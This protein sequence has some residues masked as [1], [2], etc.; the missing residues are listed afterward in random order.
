MEHAMTDELA[1]D[2]AELFACTE[3]SPVRPL[4]QL[5]QLVARTV[6]GCSGATATLW[7]VDEVVATAATH[8]D[9]AALPEGQFARGHGPVIDALRSGEP[10][11]IPDTLHGDRWLE[12]NAASLAAGVR[13]STTIAHQYGSMSLT[14]SLYGVRPNAF[15]P[16]QLPLATLLAAFGAATMAGAAEHVSVQ[17]NAAQLREAIGSR[18]VV[19]QAK[20]ILMQ[21][22]G[23]DGDEAFARLRRISQTQHVKLTDVARQ[24]IETRADPEQLPDPAPPPKPAPPR[25][26]PPRSAPPRS[27]PPRS[28]PPR[29]AP[30]PRSA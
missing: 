18:T 3:D 26:A 15:E 2:A 23:C 25:S 5:I 4:H 11:V 22:L 29:S 12:F 21:L 20:G 8:P 14:L 28:A 9:L 16:D 10:S 7:E 13:S 1:R 19:D 17:R 30:P 27:A 24:V 6:P